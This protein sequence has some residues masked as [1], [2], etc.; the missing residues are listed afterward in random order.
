MRPPNVYLKRADGKTFQLPV[1]KLSEADQAY[2][3]KWYAENPQIS[4]DYRFEKE[5]KDRD[6]LYAPAKPGMNAFQWP[7]TAAAGVKMLDSD[8][9][10]R[11]GGPLVPPGT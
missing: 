10:G 3:K 8:F 11:P 2:I 4:L 9:H 1:E 5:K 7:M 6:G